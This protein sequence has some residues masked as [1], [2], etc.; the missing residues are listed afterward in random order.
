MTPDGAETGEDLDL[1][2]DADVLRRRRTI[3]ATLAV[4]LLL[5]GT[6]AVAAYYFLRPA[7]TD[8]PPHPGRGN[9]PPGRAG[10]SIAIDLADC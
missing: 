7:Y 10:W 3:V 5:L 2:L 8:L 4:L 6:M 9:Q 1:G